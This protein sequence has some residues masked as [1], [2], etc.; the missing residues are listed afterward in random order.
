LYF[1]NMM[2]IISTALQIIV[3]LGI[4]NVW[5]IRPG[6]ATSY[7]GGAAANLKEE[8][9]AY[10]LPEIA[11]YIVGALKISAAVLLLIGLFLPGFVFPG[12]LLMSGLMLGALI[13]H[14]KVSDPAIRYLPASVMLAMS[15]ILLL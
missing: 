2:D 14:A 3:P 11:F 10:G 1:L 9:R 7:R 13:M 4:F 15:V 6:K 12:A 8:F 5:L